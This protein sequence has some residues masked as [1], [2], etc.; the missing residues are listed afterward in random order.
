MAL[1]PTQLV[2]VTHRRGADRH[3]LIEPDAV[4]DLGGLAHHHARPVVDEEAPAD[5]RTRVDVDPGPIVRV[6]GHDPRQQRHAK[7]VQLVSDAE[8]RERPDRGI[9]DHDL[10]EASR[11]R[12]A[13]VGRGDVLGEQTSDGREPLDRAACHL[14]RIATRGQRHLTDQRLEALG[15]RWDL[16]SEDGAIAFIQDEPLGPRHPV[17]RVVGIEQA[18]AGGL[19]KRI[20]V[21]LGERF[22]RLREFLLV[23]RQIVNFGGHCQPRTRGA[24][25]GPM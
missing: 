5:R 9:G 22:D 8:D 16:G 24:Q 2:A 21:A 17:D 4:A 6:L 7:P 13:G 11:G 12:V 25:R 1:A 19:G 18:T 10:V 20:F 23:Q 14:G 3:A 15:K